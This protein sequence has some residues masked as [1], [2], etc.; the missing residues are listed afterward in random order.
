MMIFD[1][2]EG[3]PTLDFFDP[4]LQI[5]KNRLLAVE[6][7]ADPKIQEIG[8]LGTLKRSKPM[9]LLFF[10]LFRFLGNF[11]ENFTRNFWS[12]FAS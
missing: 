7:S 2:F 6:I 12:F 1:H 8:T 10:G 5:F 3:G 11:I 9:S 4:Q